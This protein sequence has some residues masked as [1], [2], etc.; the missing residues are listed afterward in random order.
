MEKRERWILT[1]TWSITPGSELQL[2][3]IIANPYDPLRTLQ[4]RGPI[5]VPNA[6]LNPTVK[7][8]QVAQNSTH[9][10]AD[11]FRRWANNNPSITVG[12]LSKKGEGSPELSWTFHE[13]Q[14]H[15]MRP[16]L[17]Y[18]ERAIE[19][20]DVRAYSDGRGLIRILSEAIFASHRSVYMVTGIAVAIG[21]QMKPIKIDSTGPQESTQADGSTQVVPI[22]G[23]SS[24]FGYGGNTNM[25]PF[26]ESCDFVFAYQLSE[27]RRYP[28]MEHIPYWAYTPTEHSEEGQPMRHSGILRRTQTKKSGLKVAQAEESAPNIKKEIKKPDAGTKLAPT[29]LGPFGAIL[30]QGARKKM[31]GRNIGEEAKFDQF[32]ER[33]E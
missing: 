5:P 20:R 27:I 4:P 33:I 16:E 10:L 15:I 19:V 24:G 31:V 2:G 3:T 18:V 13:L 8:E 29:Q 12:S 7:I 6:L 22:T 1:K 28:R 21:A 32:M 25:D 23:G 17:D 30:R 9:E 11:A 14:S 26:K